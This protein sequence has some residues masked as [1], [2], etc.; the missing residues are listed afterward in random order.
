MKNK[1][2]LLILAIGNP[3]RGDDGLGPQFID[4]L[5]KINIESPHCEWD[6]QLGIEHSELFSKFKCVLIVDATKTGP[7]PFQFSSVVP[8]A[9]TYF[10]SHVLLPENVV[11]LT[12]QLYHTQLKVYLLAIKGESFELSEHLSAP[13]RSNLLQAI[14]WYSSCFT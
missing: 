10:S 6:Y 2:D 9:D 13:A 7:G 11:A 14:D 12:H 4:E 3:A 8:S 5:K 1:N